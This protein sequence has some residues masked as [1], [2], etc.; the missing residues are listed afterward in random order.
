MLELDYSRRG[1]ML[2]SDS[3]FLPVVGG[4]RNP[5]A[6]AELAFG[7]KI[8]WDSMSPLETRNTLA[9]ALN[10]PYE[11]L[12]SPLHDSPLYRKNLRLGRRGPE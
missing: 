4:S 7:K 8:D 9:K 6:L 11:R 5:F 2:V 3:R 1:V 10:T 12:F